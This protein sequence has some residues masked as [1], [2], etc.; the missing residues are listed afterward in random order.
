MGLFDIFKRKEK[1]DEDEGEEISEQERF[2]NFPEMLTFKLLFITKPNLNADKIL[3]EAKKYI[4]NIDS[5]TRQ[6]KDALLFSFP[7]FKVELSDATIPAQ[8]LVANPDEGKSNIELPDVAFQQNWHWKDANEVVGKCKYEVLVTDFMSRTLPYKQRINLYMDFLVAT[9]KA[10]NPDVLYSF[11]GQKIINPTDLINVWGH[12]DKQSLYGACNVR[13]YNI[14]DSMN[15]EVL[16][17]TIGLH[18]LGLPDFQIRFSNLEVNEVASLLWN[19]AY[20]IYENE[21]IIENGNTLEGIK[22]GSK[23]KCE[24][25]ISLVNPKRVVLNVQPN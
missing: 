11:H 22:S 1:E 18:S 24:R 3:E 16:M 20:Y 10:V 19:Y 14:G 15:K 2:E 17:D 6:D 23:W 8:C 7:D 4:L 5:P 13:L 9:M 12:E 25:Q 21:D